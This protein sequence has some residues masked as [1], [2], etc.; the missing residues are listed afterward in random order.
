[1]DTQI[2]RRGVS[3]L[4]LLAGLFALEAVG[5]VVLFQVLSDLDCRATGYHGLC[6][7]LRGAMVHGLC[8]FAGAVIL[9]A[10]RKDL[11]TSL[12]A[13][14]QEVH[15]SARFWGWLHGLGMVV[16]LLPRIV[17]DPTRLNEAFP[18]IF[19]GLLV[20]GLLAGI[21]GLF[22]LLRPQAWMR[23]LGSAPVPIA[24][25]L[26][27]ALLTPTLATIIN[28]L[29]WSLEILVVATFFG[30]AI[31]LRAT[32]NPVS[33]NPETEVIGTGEFLVQVADTCSGIEGLALTTAFM[34][35]YSV[36]MYGS[37]RQGRFWLFV[38]PAA[39]LMSFVFNIF[40][41]TGLIL[42]GAY[43][44]PDLA[45]NGFHSFAGWLAFTVLSLT[46]LVIVQAVPGLMR[47]DGPK[48]DR[49][50]LPPLREDRAAAFIFP[51]LVFM[52]A[53]LVVNTFYSEPAIGYPIQAGAML[54]ALLWFRKPFLALEWRLDPVAIGTGVIIGIG[55]ILTA[56]EPD[57][58]AGL[59]EMGA[60]A[61]AFWVIARVLGTSILVPVVEEAF[62]RGYVMGLIDDGTLIRRVA[63]VGVT[64]AG[65]ALLHGRYLEAG[66]AGLIFAW[67]ALRKGRVAD[68]IVSH[69]VANALIA[70]VALAKGDWSLI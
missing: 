41:I 4:Y 23:W 24:A 57:P 13:A 36:L 29:W 37:L 7:G 34:G 50:T 33:M 20:G 30:V 18:L 44:S 62:F 56:G 8:V 42:I 40:R 63:A 52:L 53:G 19:T 21:G 12:I 14:T 54:A 43:V 11:R 70:C 69:A 28:P 61:L 60:G 35:I 68:A 3:R 27:I 16:I 2:I 15:A 64:T 47:E 39:L 32:G 49:A 38:W 51:F 22:W 65:F 1:M 31:V 55:W 9:L 45:V 25:V 46:I 58:I 66:I 59:S 17:S 6:R 26:V 67:V 5:L 10:L 48:V